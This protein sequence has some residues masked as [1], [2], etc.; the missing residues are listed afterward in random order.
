MSEYADMAEMGVIFLES[1]AK[2]SRNLKQRDR[3]R[4][5]NKEKERRRRARLEQQMDKYCQM[6]KKMK[7]VNSDETE[8]A[9]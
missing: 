5:K 4:E 9:S 1:D 2:V 6:R 3:E 8:K 7:M